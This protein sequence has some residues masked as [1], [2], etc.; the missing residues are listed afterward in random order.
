[1]WLKER[2]RGRVPREKVKGFVHNSS[3]KAST[4]T[5]VPGKPGTTSLPGSLERFDAALALPPGGSV[6]STCIG[7]LWMWLQ[8]IWLRGPVGVVW[9]PSGSGLGPFW[10]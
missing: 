2:L 7:D 6:P 1:M 9:G 4:Y 8:V 10:P 3:Q 5:R